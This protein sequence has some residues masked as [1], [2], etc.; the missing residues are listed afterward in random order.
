VR[1][2]YINKQSLEKFIEGALHEDIG[3]GDHTTLAVI[4]ENLQSKAQLI[5]KGEGILA[6][7]EVAKMIFQTLDK[8]L[9]WESN[10]KDGDRVWIG[11]VAFV[12]TAKAR[13]ILTG[14]R[15]ALNCMQRMSGIATKTQHLVNQLRGTKS[16]ILDT[17]K[18]TPNFRMME[19]WAVAIGEGENHRYGL[20][21]MILLKD[22]HIDYAGGLIKAVNQVKQ[23]LK[24]S[25]KKLMIEVETRTMDE[26]K[27][28]LSVGGVDVIMLDNMIPSEM[29]EAVQLINKKCK[30]EASGGISELNVRE[31]AESGVDYVSIGALTHSYNSLDMSLKAIS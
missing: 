17:R 21:D 11:D 12:I 14:E 19:K 7:M 2:D 1:P 3:E 10:K 5:I 27:E 16:T 13:A 15:L 30:V 23:Y 8:D 24:E 22:N 20:Y 25:G 9:I 18:T 28:A 26:V 29:R 4:P 31:V 6:G